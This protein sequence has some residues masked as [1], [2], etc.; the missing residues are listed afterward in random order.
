MEKKVMARLEKCYSIAPLEYQGKR[1]ILVA[2]EK[3]D[4]C[5]LFDEKG[6]EETTVSGGARR[7]HDDG[8]G[9]GNRRTVFWQHTSFI[10]RMIR[11][12]RRFSSQRL[13]GKES[14]ISE[15]WWRLPF[16]HRF[17]I[18]RSGETY[19]LIACTLR[20]RT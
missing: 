5:I 15:P 19:Y 20:V 7:S 18:L 6:N 17:D 10:H 16:V 13:T 14:G 12:K 1:H 8:S 2:A 4:R 9:P 3:T 11:R